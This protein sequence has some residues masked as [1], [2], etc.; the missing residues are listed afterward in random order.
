MFCLDQLLNLLNNGINR[1]LIPPFDIPMSFQV[2]IDDDVLPS[3]N[4]GKSV[5]LDKMED[6][7]K[8]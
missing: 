1:K 3:Y 2:V 4:L 5:L 7:G 6:A 8:I